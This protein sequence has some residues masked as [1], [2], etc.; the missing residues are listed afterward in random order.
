MFDVLARFGDV[1]IHQSNFPST[2]STLGGQSGWCVVQLSK[3]VI[4]QQHHDWSDRETIRRGTKDM[5]VKACLGLGIEQ[6]GPSQST[7]CRHRQWMQDLGL[8]ERCQER[9][10]TLL[11]AVGLLRDD[12]PVLIDSVPIHGARQ[13]LDSYN[14]LAGS[15]RHGLQTLSK[16]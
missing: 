6:C 16:V 5:E 1:V 2:D 7:L 13:V 8:T 11:R 3:L 10:N 9:F 12:E 4:L 14:L 15:V